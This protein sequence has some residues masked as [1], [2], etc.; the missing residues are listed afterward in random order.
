MTN[1]WIAEICYEPE[2]PVI[3][4]R[5]DSS[6]PSAKIIDELTASHRA[7]RA[8]QIELLTRQLELELRL[9]T[10]AED[11]YGLTPEERALL[12]ATRPVRDPIDVLKAKIQGH[13]EPAVS[14]EE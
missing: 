2:S 3:E 4:F 13:A 5:R 14:R 7:H 10:L 1:A 11:A 12:H 9:A 6:Q 8:R